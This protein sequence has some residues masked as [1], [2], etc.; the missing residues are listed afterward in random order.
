[1]DSGSLLWISIDWC[2]D[3]SNSRS[4]GL[5]LLIFLHLHLA[6]KLKERRREA[7]L[8]IAKFS[9]RLCC[10]LPCKLRSFSLS[11]ASDTVCGTETGDQRGVNG[12]RSKFLPK[13]EPSA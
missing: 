9:R 1:M 2:G 5:G 13:F 12:S 7:N 11:I 3:P 4:I 6:H 10:H 8:P